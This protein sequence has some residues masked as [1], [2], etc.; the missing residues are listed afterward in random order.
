MGFNIVFSCSYEINTDSI[1]YALDSKIFCECFTDNDVT[2][3]LTDKIVACDKALKFIVEK[4]D[5]DEYI[6][7]VDLSCDET[8]ED[9]F[10]GVVKSVIRDDL[11]AIKS[12]LDECHCDGCVVSDS[13]SDDESVE[14]DESDE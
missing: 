6:K 3:E 9:S 14:S 2:P 12:I 7:D 8:P 11:D 1:K 10:C 5:D 4:L 13:E